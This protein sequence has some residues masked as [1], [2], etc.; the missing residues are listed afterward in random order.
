MAEFPKLPLWTDAY[1][2]DTTHLTTIEHGAYLLLLIAM[3]RSK[4]TRLPNDDKLLARYSRLTAGQW[5]RIKL[6]IMPFFAVE[7]GHVFQ[8]R[9]TDEANAV[10]Q[11]SAKQ[12]DKAKAR[13]RKTKD[14]ATAAAVPQ[15]CRNDASQSQSLPKEPTGS[16]GRARKRA[17]RIP[18]D[19]VLSEEQRALAHAQGLS[20]AEA[21]A[22]FERFKNRNL[23]KGQTY[24]D[25]DRAWGNWLTSPY[26]ALILGAVH[27]FPSKGQSR[28]ERYRALSAELDARIAAQPYE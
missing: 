23:A 20:D 8:P 3:W 16:S 15:D 14:K 7:D 9:L 17:T 18:E 19:A 4:G 1:L 13:H 10:R 6:V 25:W 2:G 5:S 22:Q 26:F 24:A 27:P 12:S 11:H 21:E 28:G